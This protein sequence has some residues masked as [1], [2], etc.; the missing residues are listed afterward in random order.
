[1]FFSFFFLLLFQLR[2]ISPF[3][4]F[5]ECYINVQLGLTSCTVCG[6]TSVEKEKKKK[7]KRTLTD[8]GE[9]RMAG[10]LFSV[11]KKYTHKNISR[12][13]RLVSHRTLFVLWIR[14]RT[15]DKFPDSRQHLWNHRRRNIRT[16]NERSLACISRVS[17]L[18]SFFGFRFL[19]VKLIET[20]TKKEY[21]YRE[22]KRDRQT[23]RE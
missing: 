10:F 17:F 20:I 18:S 23:D 19:D 11:L 15:F 1:M 13:G 7:K 8:V 9:V 2:F 6:L 3:I 5:A 16:R 4:R 12:Y 14:T 21:K 22:R